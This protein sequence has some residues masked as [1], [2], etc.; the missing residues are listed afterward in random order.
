MRY[1]G[2]QPQYFPRLHYF[3]RILNTNIFMLRDDVQFVRDHKYPNGRRDK[4]Y[5][6]HTPIKLPNGIKLLPVPVKNH[7]DPI[8]KTNISYDSKWSK[9]H[10][11]SLKIAY[12]KAPNFEYF[13]PE[14]ESMLNEH[15]KTIADLNTTT[16]LWGI[17]HIL[18][19]NKVKL[20]DL[21]LTLVNKKLSKQKQI[22]LTEIRKASESKTVKEKN[23]LPTNEAIVSL[24]KEV[25]A[26]EDYCGGTGASAYMDD[27]MFEKS[28]IKIT[29]QDWK[30]K[31]Y[32]QLFEK[33][34]GFIPN[35]SIIDLLMNV[36][37]DEALKIVN[38]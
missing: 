21:N 28:G 10:L 13:Y 12:S 3:A 8:K 33:E 30:C 11:N 29:I 25:G 17:L 38:S 2:I 31:P 34:Q 20:E 1:S 27:S 7:L 35:L 16:I 5:Q 22:S 26:N 36:S 37:S 15:Y 23:N 19:E 6:I 14:I 18:G 9:D 32:P 24:I 4:S